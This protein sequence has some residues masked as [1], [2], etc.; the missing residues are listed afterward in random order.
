MTTFTPGR[1]LLVVLAIVGLAFAAPAVSA[2]DDGPTDDDAPPNNGTADERTAW[3]DAHMTDHMG[4]GA[5]DWMAAHMGATVDEMADHVAADGTM[6][7]H[8]HGSTTHDGARS[9]PGGMGSAG[10]MSASGCMGSYGGMGASGGS[11]C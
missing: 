9:G 6:A 3:I 5:V 1:W 8:G 4:P 11:H 10:G 7:G 2:H